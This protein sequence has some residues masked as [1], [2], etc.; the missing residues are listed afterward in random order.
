MYLLS[1]YVP[2]SHLDSVKEALFAVG[3]G[4]MGNY[5]QCSWQIQGGGQFCAKPGSAPYIGDQ[6]KLTTIPEYKV[7][8]ICDSGHIKAVV[9]A[10]KKAHPYEEPA[11]FVLKVAKF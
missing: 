5:E 6:N 11:Y 7:E 9:K 2:A 8:M 3:A 4:K 10:L 1:F